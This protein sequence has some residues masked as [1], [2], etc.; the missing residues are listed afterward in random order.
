MRLSCGLKRVVLLSLEGKVQQDL[1]AGLSQV[2]TGNVFG[3]R[4]SR[5][6]PTPPL[7]GLDLFFHL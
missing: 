3:T 2:N 7:L 5:V 6:R 1:S 4:S